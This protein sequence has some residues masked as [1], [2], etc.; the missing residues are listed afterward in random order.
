M[1][2]YTTDAGMF[3]ELINGLEYYWFVSKLNTDFDKNSDKIIANIQEVAKLI[4]KKENLIIGTGCDS[5]D[6]IQFE[7]QI[8]KLITQ[9]P[10]EK[11]EIKVWKFVKTNKNEGLMAPSKVQFVLQ[12]CDF[13]QLGHK[14]DGK[15]LVLNNIISNV[16]LQNTIRVI[17]G[18]YGGFSRFSD[19]GNIYFASFRDPNLKETLDNYAACAK[20]LETFEADEEKMLGYI[21]GAISS[22]DR[23]LRTSSKATKAYK[24]YLQNETQEQQQADRNAVLST[25]AQDINNFSKLVSD[26]INQNTFSVYG[27]K[28]KLEQNKKLFGSL[29][30]IDSK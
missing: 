3:Y 10:A 20:Y 11:P 5:N 19:D 7:N 23:P 26:F 28:E 18:A 6:Y 8:N 21:I 9:L 1:M 24:S 25:T 14:W 2:S 17:G 13:K 4:F 12:G 22:I 15:M 27:N 30:S 16:Y 29:V